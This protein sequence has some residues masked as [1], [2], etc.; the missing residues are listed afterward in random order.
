MS[1]LEPPSDQN[2]PFFAYGLLKP[3]E[4]AFPLLEPFVASRE[5]A[6]THGKL[7]LRDGIPLLDPDAGGQVAGWLLW[8]EP[9]ELG[10]RGKSC[11]LSS[12][13]RSTGGR[14]CRL[15]QEQEP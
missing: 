7:W 14:R 6:W 10:G 11:A 9:A 8:F 13:R 4:L 12:Q 3:G 1:T 5:R 15:N 2:S